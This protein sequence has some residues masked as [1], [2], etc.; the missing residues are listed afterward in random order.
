LEW[1]KNSHTRDSTF[2]A[3]G[4]EKFWLPMAVISWAI[5]PSW[6]EVM[7]STTGLKLA[8]KAPVTTR[9]AAREAARSALMILFFSFIWMIPRCICLLAMKEKGLLG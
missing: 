7:V 5:R 2:S 8:A 9:E 1:C 3:V 6:A 4:E